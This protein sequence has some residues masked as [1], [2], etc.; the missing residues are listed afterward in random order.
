MDRAVKIRRNSV[1]HAHK[2]KNSAIA[3]AVTFAFVYSNTSLAEPK[4]A[5]AGVGALSCGQYLRPPSVNKEMSDAMVVT[6]IQG[7]LSGTNTQRFMDSET[8]M[9]KQPDGETLTAFVDKY[10]RDHPLETVYQASMNLD[11]SY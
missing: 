8:S 5:I 9:K 4:F 1:A 10:C 7:Y 2:T 3:L 6:W 11:Q